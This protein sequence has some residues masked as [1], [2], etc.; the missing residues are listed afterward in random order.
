MDV[1]DYIKKFSITEN[2]STKKGAYHFTG[3]YSANVTDYLG[4][5]ALCTTYGGTTIKTVDFK[6]NLSHAFKHLKE[7][8]LNERT[9]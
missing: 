7:I 8:Y 1:F 3:T 4:N 2:M 5:T 6:A 9:K